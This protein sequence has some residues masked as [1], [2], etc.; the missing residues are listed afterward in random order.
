MSSFLRW[1][2]LPSLLVTG[3]LVAPSPGAAQGAGDGFLFSPPRVVVNLHAGFA[4]PQADSEVFSFVSELLTVGRDDFQ[5]FVGGA[6]LSVPVH[7]RIA[8]S[9]RAEYTGRSKDSEFREFVEDVNGR[10]VP[11]EQNTRFQR[12]P[13]TANAKMNLLPRGRS[14][15]SLAWV[16]ARIVPFVGVGAGAVWYRLSQVGD[17]VDVDDLGIFSDE[18]ESSG[19]APAARGFAGLEYTLTPRLGLTTQLDYLWS[20]GDLQRDFSNFD[21]IDLSGFSASAG[22]LL[23]L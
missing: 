2:I 4:R 20:R 9:L 14:I 22:L 5:G 8:V 3:L 15:G 7:P 17:F 12:V 1:S 21:D 23:R 6:D 19:W 13:V 10:D 11:I 16:P 18:L